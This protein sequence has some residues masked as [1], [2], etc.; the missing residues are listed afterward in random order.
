M[1]MPSQQHASSK[2]V[3]IAN[4]YFY[5]FRLNFVNKLRIERDSFHKETFQRKKNSFGLNL[6]ENPANIFS[7][8]VLTR[9]MLKKI[10]IN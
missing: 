10:I 9:L 1:P 4:F 7:N 3:E 8:L 2:M 5:D 6:G